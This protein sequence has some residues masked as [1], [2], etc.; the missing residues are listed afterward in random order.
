M[1]GEVCCWEQV[2]QVVIRIRN[3]QAAYEVQQ[4]N[5]LGGNKENHVLGSCDRASWNVGW[6]EINQKVATKPMFIINLPSQHISG[7]I[8]PIIRRT[9]PCITAYGV[10][11]W[12][13]W[14]V[15]W[16]WVVH[17]AHSLWHSSTQPQ[18]AQPVQNTIC[19]NTWSCSPADGHNDARNMLR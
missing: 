18:P 13:C 12:L 5:L 17:S 1:C 16:S 15:V 3:D 14:L 7:I 9:R 8:M 6:R 10:L 19:R 2:Q 11:H 4:R